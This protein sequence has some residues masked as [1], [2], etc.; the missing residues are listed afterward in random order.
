MYEITS[1]ETRNIYQIIL[2][3]LL[4]VETEKLVKIDSK[5]IR[6]YF[7]KIS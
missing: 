7:S 4:K 5:I 1:Y 3:F 6:T 2:P